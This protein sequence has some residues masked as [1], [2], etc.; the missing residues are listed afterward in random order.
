MDFL[1]VWGS[2][3]GWIELHPGLASWVQAVGAVVSIWIAWWLARRQS[4][5]AEL[6]EKRSD[7]AKCLSIRRMIIYVKGVYE[8]HGSMTNNPDKMRKL[9]ADLTRA[10][11]L[12]DGIDLYSLPDASLIDCVCNVR[13]LIDDTLEQFSDPR[14]SYHQAVVYRL[15]TLA[16]AIR[17]LDAE[18]GEC[19][20]V[21]KRFT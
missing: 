11:D 1:M 4:R 8:S 18:I 15:A 14:N 12:M 20:K 2:F 17:T 5:K 21:V 10:K 19:E 16:P 13:Q 3:L 6:A 9:R 7:R